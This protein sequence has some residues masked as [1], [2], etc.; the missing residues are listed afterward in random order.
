MTEGFASGRS[1]ARARYRC[2]GDQPAVHASKRHGTPSRVF[3]ALPVYAADLPHETLD[4]RTRNLRG[5]VLAVFQ[6]SVLMETIL[7]TTRKP[8]GF[9]LYF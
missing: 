7:T 2:D 5:Y 9:D 6:T 3:V 8:S 4:E 1:S